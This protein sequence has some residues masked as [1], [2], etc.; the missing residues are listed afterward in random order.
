MALS[1]SLRNS[2]RE[3]ANFLCEY[4]QTAEIL[5]GLRCTT[6]HII[7][8][9]RGGSDRLDN[10]CAACIFCNGRKHA[11]IEGVDPETGQKVRLF[12]PRQQQWYEHFQWRE[13]GTIIVGLTACGRATIEVLQ[14]NEPLRVAARS[15]WG[16]AGRHPPSIDTKNS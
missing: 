8:K 3:R 2:V 16:Q 15:I 11:K 14:L 4:S 6:D 10:L 9:S 12:H 7:P 1:E 13:E 5:S